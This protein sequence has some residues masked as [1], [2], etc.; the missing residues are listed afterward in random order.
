MVFTCIICGKTFGSKFLLN[1]HGMIHTGERAICEEDGCGKSYSNFAN[2]RRHVRLVHEPERRA[3]E[4]REARAEQ[5]AQ[6]EQTRNE[7][8][9][10]MKDLMEFLKRN[11]Y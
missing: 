7:Q 5:R 1:D 4:R 6:Q 2:L 11:G 8:V 10:L 3:A 9:D